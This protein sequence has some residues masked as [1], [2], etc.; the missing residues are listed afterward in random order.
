MTIGDLRS[1]VVTDWAHDCV[2]VISRLTWPE[3]A[4][5]LVGWKKDSGSI[6]YHD[7][8]PLD[9]LQLLIEY[10]FGFPLPKPLKL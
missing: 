8:I 9:T 5:L 3:L 7:R 10:V 2:I 4:V 6:L 1:I